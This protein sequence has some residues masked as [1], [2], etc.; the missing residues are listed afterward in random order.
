M[1]M[2]FMSLPN[3]FS[4]LRK[5]AFATSLKNYVGSMREEL[6]A[7]PYYFDPEAV[8]RYYPFVYDTEEWIEWF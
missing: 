6:K 5:L 7:T 3:P 2:G 1:L 4:L 8:I